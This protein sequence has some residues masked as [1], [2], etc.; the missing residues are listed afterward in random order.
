LKNPERTENII[1]G[2][3]EEDPRREEKNPKRLIRA[4]N[5]RARSFNSWISLSEKQLH[6]SG[7]PG[8]WSSTDF[9]IASVEGVKGNGRAQQ[10]WE[11]LLALLAAFP[12]RGASRYR[13]HFRTRCK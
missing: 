8:N 1:I 5:K 6:L 13:Q 3:L 11:S 9:G 4:N 12:F 7:K 10:N 2:G